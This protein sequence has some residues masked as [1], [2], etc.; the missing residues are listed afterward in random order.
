MN[1]INDTFNSLDMKSKFTQTRTYLHDF[2]LFQSENPDAIGAIVWYTQS[3]LNKIVD[4]IQDQHG[5]D[6]S[7]R[8]IEEWRKKQKKK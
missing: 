5:M 3:E 7:E 2:K 8:I 4:D 6:D 1:R